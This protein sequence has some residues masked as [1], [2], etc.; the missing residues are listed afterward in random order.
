MTEPVPKNSQHFQGIV[1]MI[2]ASLIWPSMPVAIA[3][4][5]STVSPFVQIATRFT[6]GAVV[7]APFARNLNRDLVRDGTILGVLMFAA[8][9][10]Q[11][12]ALE[13]IPANQAS[14]TVGL[15]VILI[16][17]F[18]V[19]FYRR[20]SLMAILA[21]AIAFTGIGIMSWENGPP[22]I[23]AVWMLICALL[24]AAIVILLEK[25]APR[26]PLLPL[27][28]IQLWVIAIL[29]WL[30]VA[31]Q[32]AGQIEIISTNL[33]NPKNLIPLLYLGIVGTGIVTW[34]Q[35]KALSRITAFEGGL[36]Q[37]LEPVF[38]SIYAFFLLGETFSLRGY[39]GAVMVIA[40]MIVALS[41][42]TADALSDRPM[43]LEKA[44]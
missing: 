12:M 31:P 17:L 37:T 39:I 36:I 18:E 23:G 34:L 35:A 3:E 25:F 24:I 29:S 7:F 44:A 13:S 5:I 42:R 41:Q 32:L 26:H 21:A 15:V 16:T 43:D 9:V 4:V 8:F 38:G 10:T 30:L 11:T 22:P 1:L 40:G 6:I 19:V 2:M 20:L 28:V 14:F 27:T 33:I